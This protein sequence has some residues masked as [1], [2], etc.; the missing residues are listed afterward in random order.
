MDDV[1]DTPSQQTRTAVTARI[2]V[3]TDFRVVHFWAHRQ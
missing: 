3:P 2:I 1:P